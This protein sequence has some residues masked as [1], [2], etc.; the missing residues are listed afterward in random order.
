MILYFL[1]HGK[2]DP[3]DSKP[4]EVRQLTDE[5]RAALRAA[6]PY[7]KALGVKP[8][9]VLT[10][11]RQRAIDTA[12]LFIAGVG[13][14]GAAV[15]DEHLAPDAKWPEI[16]RAIAPHGAAGSVMLVGHEPDL[17]RSVKHLTGAAVRLREGSVCRVEFR[18]SPEPGTGEITLLLDPDLYVARG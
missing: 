11:P 12:T 3:M 8:D 16:A 14:A 9:V 13:L 2:A 18:G 1:R 7:W 10:S 5:G 17:S 6:A 4:D 15:A